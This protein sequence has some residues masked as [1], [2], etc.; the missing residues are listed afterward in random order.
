M[1]DIFFSYYWF[2]D[3]EET[4]ITSIR[5][6]GLDKK[7]RNICLRIDDFTPYVYIELP[8]YDKRNVKINWNTNIQF[9]GNKLD[10]LLKHQKP[11][12]KKLVYKHKLYGA[13]IDKEGNRKEFPYLKCCF[14]TKNDYKNLFFILRKTI[15]IFGLGELKLKMHEHDASPILQLVSIRDIPTAGWI[16]FKGE[17]VTGEDKITI[18]DRE[19][20]VSY[21]YIAKY[22]KNTVAKPKLMGFDIEVNSTNPSA[23]PKSNKQGDKI[24]QISCVFAREGD[25]EENYEIYL[26]TLGKVDKNLLGEGNIT[27][28]MYETEADLLE[29][30]T[31]LIRKENPNIIVGY[32][33]LKFDIQYMI[34][35]SNSNWTFNCFNNFSKLGFHKYNMA[36]KHEINWSS[37]AFKNQKFDY[38]DAEGRV[39]VDLLPLI[40]RDFK[41]NNY[42]LKTVSKEFLK[43]TKDD[44]SP[45]GIFKCYRIGIQKKDGEYSN[46]AI[47]AMSLVGKYCL[48]DSILVLKL[49]EKLQSW[50]GLCEMA[51][52]T[53]ISIFDVFTQGQ[54]RKVY[55]QIYKFCLHNNIVV[56]KDAYITKENERYVGAHVFPPVP[57][58]YESVLPFDFASLYPSSII[59]YNLDY[60][61]LVNDPTI[62]DSMCNIMDWT[63]CL[64]CQHDP[65]VIKYNKLTKYIEEQKNELKKL[66]EE[67]DNKLNKLIRN[68]YIEKINKLTE[69]LKPYIKER[70][71]IKKTIS[72]NPMCEKR[73]YRFL[74]SEIL[75]GVVPTLLQNLLD[76]RKNTRKE[77]KNNICKNENCKDIAQYGI[78][79]PIYCILHKE[80]NHNKLFENE[81][82]KEIEDLNKVL[83][84]RQLS[85]KICANSVSSTTPIPCKINGLFIYKTIEELSNG[86]W[87]RINEEQE[88]S[89]PVDGLEVWSDLGF[90]KAKYIM[91]HPKTEKLFRVNTHTGCVDC[92]GDHSLLRIDGSEVKP[93]DLIIG[94]ELLHHDFPLPIDTPD[95]PLFTELTDQKIADYVIESIDEKKAFIHGVF[96]A[97]GSCGTWGVLGNAKTNWTIFN[98]DIKL[99]ERCRDLLNEIENKEF[100]ISKY[101]ETAACYHLKPTKEIKSIVDKYRNIF[102]DNRKFKRIPEYIFNTSFKIRQAFFMGYYNGDGNRKLKKGIVIQN[103]GEI[104][105]ASLVYLMKSLGY[106][107]SINSNLTKK[108]EYI[109]R[110][111]CSTKFRN[112]NT[113]AIKKINIIDCDNQKFVESINEKIIRNEEEIIFK[114]GITFYRNI[115]IFSKRFTRQKLLDSL[116]EAISCVEKRNSYITEY[117]TDTKKIIYKKYCCGK[118]REMLLYNIKKNL[119]EYEKCNCIKSNVVKDKNNKDIY[120]DK[121]YIEYVYDIETENHH[122]AAGVGNMIVHNSMYGIMGVK[123][124]LLPLMPAAMCTTYMGRVNI[125]K[126][127]E[128]ITK[129]YGGK[130]VYGDSV[131]G[132][133]PILCKINNKIVYRTINNLPH[134]GWTKYKNEK[135]VAIPTSIEVWTE[136]GFTKVKNIIRHETK[137]E[138]FRVL[139]DTG[140]VDVTEDHGLLNEYGDKISPK[141]I[142]IG[143]KLLTHNLPIDYDYNFTH[144][145]KDLAF[146][147]GLFYADGSCSDNTWVINNYDKELLKKCKDILNN[148][149]YEFIIE[150]SSVL[151]I[152]SLGKNIYLFVKIWRQMFYDKEKYKKVPDEILWSSKEVRQSFLD[153]YYAGDGYIDKNGYNIFNNEGK[154][155]ASGLYFLLT[156]LGYNVSIN[157]KSNIYTL[158]Y[159]K[160]IHEKENVV[161][162]IVSLGKTEQYVYDLE[163]ENH[164]FSAGIGKLIVH[165]TDC[166]LATEPVLIKYNNIIDY[167]TVEELSDNNWT[168]IN[169]NKEISNAK[170]GYQIW[171]DKGF[172]DIVNV[173]RCGAIKPLSRILTHVGVVNCSNEHSLLTEKLESITPLEVEIG[174]KLCISEFPLPFDTPKEPLYKNKITKDIIENYIIPNYEYKGLTAELAFVWGLFFAD[175]SC[176]KYSY[177][178]KKTWIIIN[179][180][181]IQILKRACD[182]LNCNEKN[183]SFKILY[184]IQSSKVEV[185]KL[186]AIN[187]CKDKES[188]DML[189]NFIS[190]YRNLFYDNRKYKKIPSI[191]FNSPFEIRQSFFMGYYSGDGSNKEPSISFSN[192]GAIGS[193]GLFYLMRSIGYQVS[194]N[195]REDKLDIYKLTG[196]T[197]EIKFRYTPNAI[198]KIIPLKGNE[199]EY[200][201]DIQ[202][203]NH[204]FATGV[205]QLVVHNSNYINFPH[206]KTAEESWDY[207]LKV[208][209]EVS[210]L[211]PK[212]IKLEFEN[213]IYWQFFI[214]TKKRYMYRACGRDGIVDKKIGKKGVLLARRDNALIIRLIYEKLISMIF[215]KVSRDDVLY[216]IIEELNR[217]CSNSV[218]HNEFVITKSVGEVGNME[219]VP[220]KDEKGKLKGKIGNYTVPL[221]PKGKKERESQLKKKEAEDDSDYYKKCLPAVV[222]LAEKMRNRGQRV[223]V[224]TRLEYVIIDIGYNG[225]QYEKLEHIDYFINYNDILKVDFTYYVKLMINPIDDVLNVAFNKNIENGYKFKKDFVQEQYN[226]RVK[227]RDKVLKEL[228]SLFSLNLKFIN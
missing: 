99:L 143:S 129:K 148:T 21:K 214:L 4:D 49:M 203:A 157:N 181:D 57:G 205:G 160:N 86:D 196:S 162:K 112:N 117:K 103:K 26:L 228:K 163:T 7:N 193:A 192:K 151:K 137:K 1:A 40:Q 126:V 122:F 2:L 90:T 187:Y 12:E 178:N 130:L 111:Q 60:S 8:V 87:K 218:S 63:D 227:I 84:K 106:L 28:L 224:G 66:R 161:K 98:Q 141:D 186:V 42:Q 185:N 85:Y 204:H 138:I 96:F 213:A 100:I 124:G 210:A 219:V 93:R 183:I 34:D 189:S 167:K 225:K 147:M 9:L 76:A 154:I 190:K 15:N 169:P 55:S 27:P 166:V 132:D 110:L 211:F 123:K 207:A 113:N 105:S 217:I 107:V 11:L 65:K 53:N 3:E 97:E 72:K 68:E 67:R 120:I 131:T 164:H 35:R 119:P 83:E 118:E 165:N 179:K 39:F 144:I 174:D 41:L 125:E 43:D 200:I 173:V 89:S 184:T 172:T 156:S 58:N 14:S 139:T 19:Y 135:E 206:L 142:N 223:D 61:T 59:A 31:E 38:L 64:G 74:K 116:D 127:A 80:S 50:V 133:T 140:I 226:F 5:I 209:D 18:C 56:E 54:Q 29:G 48:K 136:N 16:K 25:K 194:I 188:K 92:T 180:K 168:R 153:G 79:K 37:S 77:I 13:E 71:D 20:I 102:Y 94:D 171:S 128:T 82:I 216:Y 170:K 81:K 109:Y 221:L 115:K 70:S 215:D 101:Y 198:K 145:N 47:K 150:S 95:F 158:K 152:V 108:N 159:S 175:G 182:I 199:N 114:N 45:K 69:E 176:G 32:N 155:G 46:K 73:Y 91:R 88:I 36:K 17:Q 201:Y 202:T 6:Y 195:T 177:N 33:I 149:E 146:V 191:I 78:D 23:M 104:G 222:Q 197:P 62:P 212:P 22:E 121:E 30:F 51:K 24:F 220:F 44:L 52:T 208:S 134:F 75:K 10:E